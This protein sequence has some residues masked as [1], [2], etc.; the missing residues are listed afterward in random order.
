MSELYTQVT[1]DDG[2]ITYEAAEIIPPAAADISD[3]LFYLD[4][5]YDRVKQESVKRRKRIKAIL[6]EKAGSEEDANPAEEDG[7]DA[8]PPAKEGTLDVDVLFQ[9]FTTRLDEREAAIVAETQLIASLVEK[10][11]LR[12]EAAEVLRHAKDPTAVAVLLGQQKLN[13][14]DVSGGESTPEDQ[15]A[16]A[17]QKA[18]ERMGLG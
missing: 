13:F 8:P 3:E 18:L 5:R 12:P 1:D 10:H 2:N 6:E 9:T 11:K 17:A 4:P 14:D 15:V 7:V 16:I